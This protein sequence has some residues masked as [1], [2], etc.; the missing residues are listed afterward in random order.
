MNWL[1]YALVFIIILNL[2]N[3]LK[4]GFLRQ[5]AGLVGFCAALYSAAFY[6]NVLKGHLQEYLKLEQVITALAPGGEA[7]LWLTEIIANIVAFLIIFIIV[8]LVLGFLCKRMRILNKIPVVGTLN[9]L[10]GGFF[11]A[12]KGMLI[13]FL[14]AALLSLFKTGF[15]AKAVEASAVVSLSRHYIPL[16]FGLV[17][18]FVVDK[19]GRLT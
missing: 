5:I 4:H 6:C 11:G 2:Y 15:W 17:F 10:L 14:I 18:D 19:L 3:G 16:L 13:V 8:Y 9:A 7:N 1:D 12:L